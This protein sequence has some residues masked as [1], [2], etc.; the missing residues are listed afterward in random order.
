[1]PIDWGD[2]NYVYNNP[3]DPGC[4]DLHIFI[5]M[6]FDEQ[7]QPNWNVKYQWTDGHA[8][9]LE[10]ELFDP[11]GANG[12]I[13]VYNQY[14]GN[15]EPRLRQPSTVSAGIDLNYYSKWRSYP[16]DATDPYLL[17]LDYYIYL[18][19]DP[20]S[21]YRNLSIQTN[22]TVEVKE[23]SN[24]TAKENA[25]L[26]FQNAAT[27]TVNAY[28]ELINYGTIDMT[29]T[30]WETTYIYVKKHG[31]L[32]NYGQLKHTHLIFEGGIHPMCM[33]P[34]GI[35][36]DTSRILLEDS[37]VWQLPD[38]STITLD[39]TCTLT[40]NP[41]SSI[42]FGQGSKLVLQHGSHIFADSV[43]FTSTD[44][45]YTW[46]GIYFEGISN[47]TIKNCTI[48]NASNGI[49][50][51]DNHVTGSG[52]NQPST[53]ISNCTFSNTTTTQLTN[54][55]YASNSNNVL[56]RNCTFTS[57]QLTSGFATGIMLEYCPSGVFNIIDNNIG[58]VA[59]GIYSVHSSPYIARNTITGESGSGNGIYLD[60]ANGTVKYNTVNYFVNSVYGSYSS[61]YV[62]KNTFYSPSDRMYYIVSN[63]VP[64]MRP[65]NSGTTLSWLGGNNELNGEPTYGAIEMKDNGYPSIDSGY[66]NVTVADKPY[67]SG[68]FPGTMEEMYVRYNFWGS[69]GPNSGQFTATGGDFVYEPSY[70]G[71]T[72]P[73]TDYY[74][75]TDIGFGLYD[76]VYVETLGDNPAAEQLY[77]QAYTNEKQGHYLQAIILYK[78][79]VQDYRTTD[80][81][82][83]SLARIFNCLEKKRGTLADY[84]QLQT[85]M[86][87]I[88]QNLTYFG[89]I[90][91]IAEDFML[92][93][94]VRQGLISSAI[95]D[96][97]QI[98]QHNLNNT[99]GIH[100][101]INKECLT[102]LLNEGGDL[103]SVQQSHEKIK[104]HKSNILALITV[105]KV[106]QLNISL[107]PNIPKQYKLYQNYPNPFNPVTTIKYDIPKSGYVTFNIYDLL[108]REIYSISEYKQAGSYNIRFDGSKYASGLYFYRIEAGGYV[109]V[110]KMVL[111]K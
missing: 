75:L 48:E 39:S 63:S 57:T 103:M 60:N 84:Q 9:G 33:L 98:Y 29:G 35:F 7:G 62:L 18:H 76:T 91:D 2:F 5:Y 97:D 49:N 23:N 79:V 68:N 42:Q 47:D 74:D 11:N 110:K 99:K 72:L 22:K 105:G 30:T 101:L 34:M 13:E 6:G 32:C 14:Y 58:Y 56:I 1:V 83:M 108:G 20:G 106:S 104:Q 50:I 12:H 37:A 44:A 26:N 109:E 40:M 28:S 87:L 27:C 81:A 92:K 73:P 80:Y 111:I 102:V 59:T 71:S 8:D 95:N 69:G 86:N 24:F 10:L 77:M 31:D 66:N 25:T 21:L 46:D 41:H 90:R 38:N 96:Y 3:A 100:A 15:A 89:I 61:P 53:E 107:N 45:G 65:I 17:D 78:Q 51:I 64:V 70:D 43:I 94:K 67:I 52:F 82:P 88:R 54:G 16:L 36:V 55:I 4:N 85:Y 93:S 19:P